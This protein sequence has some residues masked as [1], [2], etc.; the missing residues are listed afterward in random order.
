MISGSQKGLLKRAQAEAGLDD[1][2]YRDA[3]AMVSGMTDCRS[4]TDARLTDRHVDNLMSY[5]EAI[6]WRKVD[7][8]QLKPVFKPNAVFRKRGYWASK[9]PKGNTSRDR[10]TAGAIDREIAALESALADLGCGMS[11]CRGIQNRMRRGGKDF[12]LVKY[13]GALKR[14][15]AAKQR[16]ASR[17]F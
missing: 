7:A 9:N 15:L 12:S 10:H 14:T 17:P 1:A 4:S 2:E 16:A 13:A 3:I 5:F 11:Y 6:Y 8:R